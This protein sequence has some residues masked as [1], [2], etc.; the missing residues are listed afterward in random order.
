MFSW[1]LKFSLSHCYSGDENWIGLL[2]NGN[3]DDDIQMKKLRLREV[4][5]L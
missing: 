1:L 3:D 4:S 2:N 5:P